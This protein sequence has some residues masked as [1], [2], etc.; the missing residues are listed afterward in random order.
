MSEQRQAQ[1]QFLSTVLLNALWL[2]R[3]KDVIV[4]GV[5]DQFTF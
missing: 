1:V 2:M 4:A 5:A 3:G